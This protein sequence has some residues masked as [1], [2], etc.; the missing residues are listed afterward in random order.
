[1]TDHERLEG[2]VPAW[3]LG[4]LDPR[5]AEEVERHV[6]GCAECA[7]AQLRCIRLFISTNQRIARLLERILDGETKS[8]E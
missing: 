2:S 6:A 3:V 4:A 5:A 8:G 1:M 7:A